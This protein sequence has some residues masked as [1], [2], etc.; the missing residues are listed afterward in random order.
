M[1][2][3]EGEEIARLLSGYVEII[4]KRRNMLAIRPKEQN[5]EEQ[6]VVEEYVKPG[7]SRN[8]AAVTT[9][10]ASQAK[11]L[12]SNASGIGSD[13]HE[14]NKSKLAKGSI[15]QDLDEVEDQELL[16]RL[17]RNG[18][19][20]I[21][22]NFR[23]LQTP[24]AIPIGTDAAAIQWR[25]D[26]ASI[27]AENLSSHVGGLLAAISAML[28]QA[29]GDTKTMNYDLMGGSLTTMVGATT[30]ATQAL[31]VLAS[32]TSSE[33]DQDDLIQCG[34][35]LIDATLKLLKELQPIVT[36]HQVLTE[37][38]NTAAKV[39]NSGTSLL[40]MTDR[41]DVP[42]L[43]QSELID[44]AGDVSS[45]LLQLIDKT[46]SN[47]ESF[48]NPN[49]KKQI[50]KSAKS[51]NEATTALATIASIMASVI[52][53][54]FA[55]DQLVD[56]ATQVRELVQQVKSFCEQSADKDA[57]NQLL[58][59]VAS[60][61]QAL[62][63]LVD[64]ARNVESSLEAEI[65]YY[66]DQIVETAGIINE[67]VDIPQELF[68]SA[69]EMA[70]LGTRL[71]EVLKLKAGQAESEQESNDLKQ[72]AS[73]IA[74]LMSQMV[75]A[76][77][78]A[79]SNPNNTGAKTQLLDVVAEIKDIVTKQCAPYVKAS[80][81]QSI[82][83]AYKATI[84]CSNQVIASGR[85]AAFSARDRSKV[86]KLTK[87]GKAVIE[88]IP[89]A[90][91][92]INDAKYNQFDFGP[93]LKLLD[94]AKDFISPAQNLLFGVE[95][96]A[97][98][99]SDNSGKT[100]LLVAS[101]KLDF[102]LQNLMAI[103][104]A[105]GGIL[106]EV[107]FKSISDAFKNDDS[108]N[109]EV[110][111]NA[112]LSINNAEL[113][114]TNHAQLLLEALRRITEAF[115]NGDTDAQAKAIGVSIA[116]FQSIKATIGSLDES[117][118][119]FKNELLQASTS[120]GEALSLFMKKISKSEINSP[121]ELREFSNVA[122]HSVTE[123]LNCLPR[124]KAMIEAIG[125]I[126]KLTDQLEEEK[127]AKSAGPSIL[128]VH[129]T[130]ANLAEIQNLLLAAATD[131]SSATQSLVNGTK[132]EASV[133]KS[134]IES[135][136]KNYGKL[137]EA[138]SRIPDGDSDITTAVHSIGLETDFFLSALQS[139]LTDHNPSGQNGQL[140]DAARGVGDMVDDL[141][142][143]FANSNRGL[144]DCT[145]ALQ[146]L[147]ATASIVSEVNAPRKDN[148][149]YADL[150]LIAKGSN[151]HLITKAKGISNS[152][153]TSVKDSNKIS[154]ASLDVCNL[155][156]ELVA[157]TVDGAHLLAAADISSIPAIPS[158]LNQEGI[159]MAAKAIKAAILRINQPAATQSILFDDA[160]AIARH[161]ADICNICKQACLIDESLKGG[162][163]EF[164]LDLA[165]QSSQLVPL[166]K[167]YAI[168]KSDQSREPML[169]GEEL[170]AITLEKVE[171]FA[172]SPEF[173]GQN[174]KPSLKALSLQQPI[175]ES[176]NS[177]IQ[178]ARNLVVSI[179]TL[180]AFPD[181][182][183]NKNQV[184]V[185]VARLCELTTQT[186]QLLDDSS[187][188][189]SEFTA[190][191][192]AISESKKEINNILQKLEAGE[193]LVDNGVDVGAFN[194]S[195]GT[196]IESVNEILRAA[197]TSD[198]HSIQHSLA[199]LPERFEM[200]KSFSLYSI[201][202]KILFRFLKPLLIWLLKQ[203]QRVKSQF[204]NQSKTCHPLS[205]PL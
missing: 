82:V 61:D 87:A 13:F 115:T 113:I 173:A 186:A 151:A 99:I 7:Q 70:V 67:A 45:A 16:L 62:A 155:L 14:A 177:S 41:I 184:A 104:E 31:R 166:I 24:M 106:S 71:T 59:A 102:E 112:L 48:K 145:R 46:K 164:S 131:L 114:L 91:K 98:V 28:V 117:E 121:K 19:D 182:A 68:A 36:G 135:L 163:A 139:S 130:D 11:S 27:N 5:M 152:A 92:C 201:T 143:I 190:A 111:A 79:L 129:A 142:S 57:L 185:N 78:E 168:T 176:C 144:D 56:A 118:F 86:T 153:S 60:A 161:S 58:D 191:S 85:Q 156:Q 167:N 21:E 124:Q 12:A 140:I 150:Q 77:R 187:P 66:Q 4:V 189:Q 54:P 146:I 10:T 147:N 22:G 199:E 105:C 6:A 197:R 81:I 205:R 29:N 43:N 127:V 40:I 73:I 74:E 192:S 159:F 125:T 93:R 149:S 8:V 157:R 116:E 23:D 109:A 84:S 178:E 162:F 110:A 47:M 15:A 141:F 123:M 101:E 128:K 75:A 134:Q 94:S 136:E 50:T 126:K 171:S 158:K 195:M 196:M 180:L 148:Y 1:E 76:T 97:P 32:L 193:I 25:Q 172:K 203:I 200:V 42:E 170:L 198:M 63:F 183:S 30:N 194:K 49:T 137:I 122:N 2:T 88:K 119:A 181:D 89:N 188:A 26:N 65:Q 179:Q 169:A 44:A 204:C 51:V 83:K 107:D 17:I 108:Q 120:V 175:V 90:V 34:K 202:L 38:H 160:I 96:A 53:N 52:T 18:V 72:T 55:R 100:M 39:A 37:F 103:L 20:T 95:E 3:K 165:K 132:K 154:A 9:S 35:D 80:M 64:K 133:I 69:K 174:A 138:A 33:E